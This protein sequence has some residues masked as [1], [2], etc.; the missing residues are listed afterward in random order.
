M[1]TLLPA[2]A[3]L[4]IRHGS[5]VLLMKRSDK[6]EVWPNFWAL[7]GGKLDEGEMFREAA[8]RE[9]LEEIGIIVEPTDIIKEVMIVHRSI[10][11][12]KIIYVGQAEIYEN[13]P[14]ILEPDLATDLAWF[15]ITELPS[16]MIPV[17]IRA[18]EAIEQ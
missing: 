3:N 15:P 1:R 8:V 13:S 10:S 14:E 9:T 6:T 18:L 4:I 11:G 17:H 5:H 12:V 2:A 7:P 16:P